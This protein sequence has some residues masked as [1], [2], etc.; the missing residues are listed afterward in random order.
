M[1]LVLSF[2]YVKS[3]KI[4]FKKNSHIISTE[5]GFPCSSADK[6]S[7][8]NAGD[9]GLIPGPGKS[10]IEGNG[11][12]LQD[13]CLDNPMDRGAWWVTAQWCYKEQDITQQLKQQQQYSI[14]YMY[15]IS[16]IYSSVEGQLSCFRVL[17]IVNRVACLYVSGY[18]QLL[19]YG[20]LRIHVQEWDCQITWQFY[21]Q[22]FK[23]L[24]YY[25]S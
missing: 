12:P 6:E 2:K 17:A 24:P 11:H 18:M 13:S 9:P 15:H 23:E 16:F 5:L 20:F 19:N 14:V 8:C 22:F 3:L 10:P 1:M 7:A 4:S 21:I 25:Y